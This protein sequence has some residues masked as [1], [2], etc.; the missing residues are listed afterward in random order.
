MKKILSLLMVLCLVVGM[1]PLTASAEEVATGTEKTEI[2]NF[3]DLQ[4]DFLL[5]SDIPFKN[6]VF[7][8]VVR[9]WKT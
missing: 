7:M 4:K 3:S 2:T 6:P 8:R 1:V 5:E 9:L